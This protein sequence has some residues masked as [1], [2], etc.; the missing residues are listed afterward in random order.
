MWTWGASQHYSNRVHITKIEMLC[1][2]V[3][4]EIVTSVV[5]KF[6]GRWAKLVLVKSK[7]L[8]LQLKV[9]IES[10]GSKFQSGEFQG[11]FR[12]KFQENDQGECQKVYDSILVFFIN[13]KGWNTPSILIDCFIFTLYTLRQDLDL[14][15]LHF[16]LKNVGQYSLHAKGWKQHRARIQQQVW[17]TR[18]R[19][20]M[21]NTIKGYLILVW[22]T[23]TASYF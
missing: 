10:I 1:V 6:M 14:F 19:N 8:T 3:R 21:W 12:D 4:T 15:T 16:S 18:R 7:D 5:V 23:N 2:H 11:C 22:C 20:L 17:A 9:K 13:R